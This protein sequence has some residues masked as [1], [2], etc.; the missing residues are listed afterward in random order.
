MKIKNIL[1]ILLFIIIETILYIFTMNRMAIQVAKL[2]MESIV[3]AFGLGICMLIIVGVICL[4][5][6]K[7]FGI[8]HTAIVI[9]CVSVVLYCVIAYNS[10]TNAIC[11]VCSGLV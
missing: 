4:I 11:P 2:H 9:I 1:S 5:L 8:S 3:A 7:K 10:F 6:K